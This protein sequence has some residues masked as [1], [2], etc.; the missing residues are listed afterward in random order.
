MPRFIFLLV[1]FLTGSTIIYSCRYFHKNE[2]VVT[3]P[4]VKKNWK[5]IEELKNVDG[6]FSAYCR[7][8]G[9]KKAFL[10]F[11]DDNGVLLRPNHYPM[12]GADALDFL[13]Q[14]DDRD[15]EINWQ[16]KDGDVSSSGDLG[17]TYGIYIVVNKK[18]RDTTQGTYVMVWKKQKSGTWKLVMDSGNNGLG[19]KKDTLE[20]EKEFQE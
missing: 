11:L 18:K 17:Y 10:E 19:E 4:L 8:S 15:I 2:D 14:F 7:D 16:P 3:E 13:S 9:M 6:E 12:E 1:C 5:E 20:S